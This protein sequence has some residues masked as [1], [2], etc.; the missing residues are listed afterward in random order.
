MD[1]AE[2]VREHGKIIEELRHSEHHPEDK[3]RIMR[4]HIGDR[5]EDRM[6]IWL[7]EESG[8]EDVLTEIIVHQLGWGDDRV[9]D[10]LTAAGWPQEKVLRVFFRSATDLV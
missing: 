3:L 5:W 2:F 7:L 1:K 4:E 9:L 10:A 8:E 6:F